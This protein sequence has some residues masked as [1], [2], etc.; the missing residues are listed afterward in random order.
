MIAGLF[1][2]LFFCVLGYAL[3]RKKLAVILCAIGVGLSLAYAYTGYREFRNVHIYGQHYGERTVDAKC[4]TFVIGSFGK[5]Q[6]Q[7]CKIIK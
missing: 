4:K 5:M 1:G 6:P 3:R 2:A 7:R